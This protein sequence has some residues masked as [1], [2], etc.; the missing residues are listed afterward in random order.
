M[1]YFLKYK[2]L[3]IILFSLIIFFIISVFSI[4]SSKFIV[5][6]EFNNL[7]IKQ[8]CWYIISFFI[9]IIVIK[10]KNIRLLNYS[11]IIY[12]LNICLLILV[13][14][15]GNEINNAKCWFTIPYLGNFQPSEIMKISLILVLSKIYSNYYYKENKDYK[16]ELKLIIKVFIFTFLPSILTF[17]EPDTGT[18][19]FYF[20][21]AFSIL[22][23]SGINYKW[24]LGFISI[25]IIVFIIF[26][27]IYFYFKTS[28]VNIFGHSFFYRINRILDWTNTSGMQ[29]E[30]SLIAIGS[31]YIF[32]HG[33]FNTPIYFP[34]PYTDFIFS[35]FCSNFGLVGSIILIIIICLFLFSIINTG[36]K[37]KTITNKLLIIGIISC[38]IF[39]YVENISM[40]IGLLPI[41]GITLPFISY[42]GSSLFTCFIMIGIIIN[43]IIKQKK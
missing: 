34:E 24:F 28:F 1:K 36:I 2:N 17:I 21:I 33:L 38:F 11:Y 7:Y 41:M 32:G 3:F 15:F 6:S 14:I 12:A 4:Y 25:I 30:N 42:G 35:V 9:M 18:V 40:S 37:D 39:S 29:L 31:S 22:F 13:L 27:V 5:N 20:L 8:I 26:F 43:I 23:I 16:E 19:I 10:I